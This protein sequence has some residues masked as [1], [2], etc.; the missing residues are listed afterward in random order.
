M[1][2]LLLV[3]SDLDG[4]LLDHHSYDFDAALGQLEALDRAGIPLI[5]A[6]SKTRAEIEPL[7]RR[8]GNCHP[9]IAENGAAVFVP[10]GYFPVTPEDTLR[11]FGYCVRTFAAPRD[12]WLTL[13]DEVGCR[14]PGEFI[15]FQAAGVDGIATMTG[16]DATAAAGAN[17]RDYS[18]P[19]RWLGSEARRQEFVAALVDAGARV[20]QGGRFMAVSGDCDKGQALRWLRNVFLAQH[21]A[22]VVHDLAIGDSGNDRDMLE[23]AETALLIR[24]PVHPFPA[25]QRKEGVWHSEAMGPGGWAEGVERWL[26]RYHIEHEE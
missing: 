23:V 15:G 8:L 2:P 12:Y 4:S 17:Q 26:Q 5:L 22:R 10:E 6:T 9:F 19:V 11:R 25:L 18:E 3:F 7:R 21:P 13:L 1:R 16:L 14:F 20:Q 24:S